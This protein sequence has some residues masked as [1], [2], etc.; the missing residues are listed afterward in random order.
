MCTWQCA[1]VCYAT[2]RT[3]FKIMWRAFHFCVYAFYALCVRIL[4]PSFRAIAVPLAYRLPALAALCVRV[5][6]CVCSVGV[7]CIVEI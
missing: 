2:A 3:R 7:P 5:C 4:L 6:M 1:H